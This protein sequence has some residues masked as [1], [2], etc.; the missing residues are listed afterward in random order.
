MPLPL[1][2]RERVATWPNERRE[3]E[4]G[5]QR[6]QLD[7]TEHSRMAVGMNEARRMV[8]QDFAS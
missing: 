5:L 7:G 6:Q 2:P 3:R 1:G 4:H 8:D